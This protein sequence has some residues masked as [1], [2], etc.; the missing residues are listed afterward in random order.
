[1]KVENGIIENGKVHELVNTTTGVDSCSV[2]SLR[3][4]CNGRMLCR[5]VSGQ[6]TKHFVKRKQG[7]R[8]NLPE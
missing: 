5:I 1:M 3:I 4:M 8:L 2:C 6:W 7:G